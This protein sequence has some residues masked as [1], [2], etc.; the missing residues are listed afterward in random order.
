MYRRVLTLLLLPPLLLQGV[1]FSHSHASEDI[2]EPADHAH[3]RHFHS[4]L[5]THPHHHHD[6]DE[7]QAPL[8]PAHDDDAVYFPDAIP[9]STADDSSLTQEQNAFVLALQAFI[10]AVSIAPPSP[11][12]VA[13]PPPLPPCCPLYLRTLTL[14]I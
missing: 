3:T 11:P 13:H 4:P 10:D 9:G 7:P 1:C 12:A 14:L 6:E 5:H 2:A 8:S